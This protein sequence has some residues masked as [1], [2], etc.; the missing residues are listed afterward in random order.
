MTYRILITG[1]RVWENVEII[2]D[3][4]ISTWQEAGSPKD[5]ILIVGRARGVDTFAEMFGETLGFTI[6]P[7]KAH[8]EKEGKSAG[9]QRN[10]RMVN[11]GAD[12]C[13]AFLRN[14][15]KG[16]ANCIKLAEKAGIPVQIYKEN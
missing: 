9:H 13:L 7:H 4:I 10:Q 16:T 6:E 11:S 5:T 3:A 12:I 14:G 2:S 1:S 8:W 15:S